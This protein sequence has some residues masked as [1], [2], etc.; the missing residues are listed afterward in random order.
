MDKRLFAAIA[1]VVLSTLPANAQTTV[2]GLGWNATGQVATNDMPYLVTALQGTLSNE[3]QISVGTGLTTTDN[4]ANGTYV[5]GLGPVLSYFHGT[6]A[7]TQQTAVNA[8]FDFPSKAADDIWYYNGTNVVRLAKG[9]IGQVVGINGSGHVAYISPAGSGTVTSVGMTVPSWLTVSGSP[10]TGAD[11]LAVTATSGLAANSFIGTPD[12]STGAVSLRTLA[13]GDI[14]NLNASKITAGNL[15]KAQ[16]ATSAVFNDQSNTF[17]GTATQN[18]S[19]SGQTLVIPVKA[20]GSTTGEI[21]LN[22]TDFEFRSAGATHKAA[23]QAI[24]IST[25]S[26]LSGGGDLSANRTLTLGTVDYTKGG[27]GL[28]T[29]TTGTVLVGNGTGYTQ[30]GPGSSGQVLKSNGTTLAMGSVSGGFGG[31]S[32]DGAIT[33]SGATGY[34]APIQKNASTFTVNAS[35]TLTCTGSPT[36]INATGAVT[37]NGTINADG[38]GYAGVA[39]T[40]PGVNVGVVG[41]DGAGPG[42][43]RAGFVSSGVVNV[44][45]SG[46]GFGGAGGYGGGSSS[47]YRATGGGTYA[48]DLG[49]GSAGGGGLY[50]T[51]AST[52]GSGG[53]SII[54]AAVGAIS[55]P[56]GGQITAV[57]GNASAGTSCV[58]SGGA[59]GGMI[60][61]AS[62][63]SISHATGSTINVSGGNGST[64]SNSNSGGGGGGG[65]GRLYRWTQGTVTAT[66][67]F[68]ATG[69]T[70]GT[71]TGTGESGASGSSGVAT[72]IAGTPNLPLLTWTFDQGG[73]NEIESIRT[74][75]IAFKEIKGESVNSLD[76]TI[77]GREVVA[78][79]AKGDLAKFALYTN[80]QPMDQ[81][82]NT[83]LCVGD[84]VKVQDNA[85]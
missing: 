2:P 33:I 81:T 25:T 40:S 74:S 68:T 48:T 66:G 5:I 82:V 42:G 34:T 8:I 22:S 27:T 56:S 64:G 51:T 46:G 38:Q 72:T 19:A 32:S 3:R 49:G 11:T 44:G 39:V 65:G 21:A 54:I 10:V 28:T 36:I 71:G 70:G 53:G 37:I 76:V 55:V 12:G 16:H 30:V 58:G 69:G 1:A 9:S 62:Q 29:A 23:K 50:V 78:R 57:G 85:A 84:H 15:A 13:S 73:L 17:T 31:D 79:A 26:P 77:D 4:G 61:L 14:P 6:G 18:F 63:T 41:T 83:V 59:S 7:T 67:T 24:T 52:P 45:G 35:Q 60:F 80:P 75:T 47:Q 20:A 43:G